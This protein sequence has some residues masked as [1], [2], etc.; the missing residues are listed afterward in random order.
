MICLLVSL[1]KFVPA[2]PCILP[3]PVS[4]AAPELILSIPLLTEKDYDNIK[5]T[6][7]HTDGIIL[8]GYCSRYKCFLM[9]YDQSKI[10]SGQVVAD[11]VEAAYPG[12]KTEIKEG[13][14]IAQL[15]DGCTR[16]PLPATG[17]ER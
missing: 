2:S 6:L 16:F 17:I 3:K 10:K 5:N 9:E 8:M 12:Y 13:T 1:D 14:T 4:V 11:I 15:I 7:S